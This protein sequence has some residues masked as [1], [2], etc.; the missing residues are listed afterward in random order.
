M[1]AVVIRVTV[2]DPEPATSALREQVVP[3]V[4]Q[5][6]G[7]VAGY[8]IRLEGDQGRAIIVFESEDAAKS[9]AEQVDAP[10]EFVTFDSVEVAE[11]VANA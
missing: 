3:R 5:L 9:A 11:V 6:P 10:G 8:W 1:H 7:F 2:N 4:K